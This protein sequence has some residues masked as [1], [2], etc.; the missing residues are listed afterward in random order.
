MGCVR[1]DAGKLPLR[2]L[3]FAADHIEVIVV[4]A[5]ERVRYSASLRHRV[6]GEKTILAMTRCRKNAILLYNV[7]GVY[8]VNSVSIFLRNRAPRLLS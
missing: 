7:F 1:P 8:F 2:C 4:F 5:R 3:G 6:A